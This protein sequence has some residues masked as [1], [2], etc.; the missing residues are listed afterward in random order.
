MPTASGQMIEKLDA[1]GKVVKAALAK[2]KDY[3]DDAGEPDSKDAIEKLTTQFAVFSPR[4]DKFA[5]EILLKPP[6]FADEAAYTLVRKLLTATMASVAKTA[7]VVAA[8]QAAAKLAVK[9]KVVSAA[10][11]ECLIK[12]KKMAQA[13]KMVASGTKGRAGPAEKDVK[14]YNHIH[15]GGNA[16]YNL[17]FQPGKKL[18]LGTLDFHLDTSCSDAQKKEIKKVA[19]RSGGTVTLV[20]SGDEITEE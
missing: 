16:R 2:M 9:V 1:D 10:K 13:L 11:S 5:R 14:E 7:K 4:I 8:E 18:V 12:D 3:L 19:A 15:I 6:I 17:L 20:I